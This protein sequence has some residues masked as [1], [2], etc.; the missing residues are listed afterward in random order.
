MSR[1]IFL[2][3]NGIYGAVLALSMIFAPTAALESYGA[4]NI[5]L[6]HIS[7]M[8]F[9]GVANLG[10]AALAF[11]NRNAPNSIAL[12]NSLLATAIVVFG[13]VVLG[14][15]NAYAMNVPYSTFFIGDTL[16]R[17][18]LGLAILYFYNQESKQAIA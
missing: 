11:L 1:S 12:R 7:T 17:L 10:F 6:N 5:D 4:A 16:F 2:L 13:G 15:Y 14:L 8:Q 9:L 18:A 3:I